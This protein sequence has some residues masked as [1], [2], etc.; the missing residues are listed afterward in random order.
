MV[1]VNPGEQYGA[2]PT[3]DP[4]YTS[5]RWSRTIEQ[6][7]AN[8]SGEIL[9]KGAGSALVEGAEAFNKMFEKSA[10][11]AGFDQGEKL[12][13]DRV[14]ELETTLNM[15]RGVPT[16][17]ALSYASTETQGPSKLD[18]LSTDK[19]EALPDRVQDMPRIAQNLE[20]ARANGTYSQSYYDM[21]KASTLKNVR[22]QY[23]AYR[24]QVDRAFAQGGETANGAIQSLLGDLN[25]Y[26]AA[27][28][29]KRNEVGTMLDAEI[30]D[31]TVG[32]AEHK[33]LFNNGQLTEDQA[34]KF[35]NNANADKARARI[36]ENNWKTAD[37]ND[38]LAGLKAEK[39]AQVKMD[40]AISQFNATLSVTTNT[41]DAVGISEA[42]KDVNAGKFDATHSLENGQHIRTGIAALRAKMDQEGHQVPLDSAGRPTGKPSLAMDMGEEKYQKMLDEHLKL[43]NAYADYFSGHEHALANLTKMTNQGITDQATSE[44][45]ANPKIGPQIAKIEAFR[46]ATGTAG[47]P[48]LAEMFNGASEFS[49][50]AQHFIM[51]NDTSIAGAGSVPETRSVNNILYKIQGNEDELSKQGPALAKQVLSWQ[52]RISDSS[53]P[54]EVRT[55]YANAFFKD[56]GLLG[57]FSDADKLSIYEKFGMPKTAAAIKDLGPETFRTYEHFMEQSFGNPNGGLFSKNLRDLDEMSNSAAQNLRFTF[58]TESNHYGVER[59]RG[60]QSE[61]GGY[62]SP[63]G[64]QAFNAAQR[65]VAAINRGVDTLKNVHEQTGVKDMNAYLARLLGTMG[66]DINQG[67]GQ[68][69]MKAMIA[70]KQEKEDSESP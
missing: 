64:E 24:T 31:G 33:T 3:P 30:K 22:D 21:L 4:E 53:L 26:A 67:I 20:A 39:Y 62:G 42:L 1:A 52:N 69:L 68:T 35:V 40:T 43:P 50:N 45:Y 46:K 29:K 55:N 27:A 11:K 12:S 13:Q 38:K 14:N 57:R 70:S 54:P 16:S 51:D 65:N 48:L 37:A 63:S 44:M 41:G 10:E 49:D 6:P 15:A 47:E 2:S 18:I 5:Y 23:P 28:N 56:Y 66:M 19:K 36:A 61:L 9:A 7:R 32:A 8:Q 25:S 59:K 60:T 17:G 34:Y 58:D